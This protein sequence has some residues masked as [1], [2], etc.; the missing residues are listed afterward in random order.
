MPEIRSSQMTFH[1][2][3]L[4]RTNSSSWC[5]MWSQ[6]TVLKQ[7]NWGQTWRSGRRHSTHKMSLRKVTALSCDVCDFMK[8]VDYCYGYDFEMKWLM[9]CILKAQGLTFTPHTHTHAPVAVGGSLGFFSKN[10]RKSD[11]HDIIPL[12]NLEEYWYPSSHLL[13]GIIS[14]SFL[15]EATC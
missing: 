3:F 1:W 12:I 4:K 2:L 5:C 7:V 8:W 13:R 10:V 9:Y 14:L 6:R 11:F 15:I